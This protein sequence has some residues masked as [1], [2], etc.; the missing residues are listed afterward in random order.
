MSLII[1]KIA[2]QQNGAWALE[3]ESPGL[4]YGPG[5]N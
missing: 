1:I 3:A 5:T 2:A 4:Q